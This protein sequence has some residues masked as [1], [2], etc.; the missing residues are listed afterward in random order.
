MFIFYT[1]I[2]KVFSPDS[3]VNANAFISAENM[4]WGVKVGQI[5]K[6]QSK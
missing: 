3:V 5:I 2:H 1:K 6:R 4:C